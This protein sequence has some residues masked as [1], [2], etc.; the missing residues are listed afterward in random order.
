M[1]LTPPQKAAVAEWLAQGASIAEVQKRLREEFQVSLTYI[2]TRFLIDDLGLAV[3]AAAPA[4]PASADLAGKNGPPPLP[5]TPPPAPGEAELIDEDDGFE[6]D[7]AAEPAGP[8]APGTGS[9]TVEVDRLTRPGTVVSGTVKFSDGNAG[10]W[11]LDQYG[12]LVFEG[13]N[14]SYRPAAADLQAFQRELSRQL[15]RHG[16]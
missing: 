7:P 2:D 11:A 3:K 9:V 5:K 12:R 15:Q 14:A 6:D 8:V 4:K 1:K 10:R 13:P 16:F